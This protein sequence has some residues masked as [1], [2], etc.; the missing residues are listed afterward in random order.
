MPSPTIHLAQELIRRPS[1]TPHDADCQQLLAQR[2]E[3]L[4]FH[5]SHLRFGEGETGGPV[6][7]LWAVKGDSGPLFCFA[8]HTDVVPVGKRE[9]WTHDPFAAEIEGDM[10][11]GRGAADMKGSIASMVV[12]VEHFLKSCPRPR[13]RIAFL[14]TS[15]EEGPSLFGTKKVVEYLESR[16]EKIT[17]CLVGE[18]SSSVKLGD[19]VKNGRRGSLSGFLTVK[20]VQGHVAYP[21]KAKNPIHGVLPALQELCSKRWDNGN[22]FFPATSLQI[23]NIQSGTGASNV[24]P[25]DARISFNLRFST[26][27]TAEALKQAIEEILR[28][29]SIDYH[30]RWEESQ[31]FL[32]PGGRLLEATTSAIQAVSGVSTRALTNGGTSDGRF[33]APTGAEVVELGPINATIHKVD[34]C[35]SVSDL[36]KLQEIYLKILEKL[37]GQE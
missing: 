1:I 21:E 12:A 4:G 9:D 24:I 32:T 27:W 28:K 16:Q 36:E 10:L 8:G 2:L 30:I 13:G 11:V 35:V 34:E 17:W 23:S 5:C 29:H 18:P 14:I 19:V 6:D 37:L 22:A 33:I 25:G 31:P 15:D 20:G 7:N 26:Q 3:Q